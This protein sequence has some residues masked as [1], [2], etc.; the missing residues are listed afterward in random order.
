MLSKTTE[1]IVSSDEYAEWLVALPDMDVAVSKPAQ[2]RTGDKLVS[3]VGN[4]QGKKTPAM[5]SK[6]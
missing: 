4:V 3:K 5:S 2:T 1:C 6:D